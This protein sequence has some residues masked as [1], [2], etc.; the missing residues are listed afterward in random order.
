MWIGGGE[1]GAFEPEGGMGWLIARLPVLCCR[2]SC[3]GFLVEGMSST[4]LASL[5]VHCLLD[6]SSRGW[7]VVGTKARLDLLLRKRNWII[8]VSSLVLVAIGFRAVELGVATF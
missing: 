4:R 5:F 3:S 8:M 7:L 1:V 2:C 6:L